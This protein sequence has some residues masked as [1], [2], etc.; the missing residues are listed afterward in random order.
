[1][2][3]EAADPA[4]QNIA[5][6][7]PR[8]LKGL[9]SGLHSNAESQLPPLLKIVA[10]LSMAG[11]QLVLCLIT[12]LS[13]NV[14]SAAPGLLAG[15]TIFVIAFDIHATNT[16]NGILSNRILLIV[17]EIHEVLRIGSNCSK[18]CKY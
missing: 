6:A 18:F 11:M 3:A 15:L 9:K 5:H 12:L 7:P 10:M 1:M 2:R 14:S 17:S 13:M 16:G 4:K 8:R